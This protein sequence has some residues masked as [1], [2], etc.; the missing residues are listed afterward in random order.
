MPSTALHTSVISDKGCIEVTGASIPTLSAGLL[1]HYTIAGTADIVIKRLQ[2]IQ[3]TVACSF[4]MRNNLPGPV[5]L[6]YVSRVAQNRFQEHNP[7]SM[8]SVYNWLKFFE[9]ILGSEHQTD[10]QYQK[11]R[12]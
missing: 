1:Q 2:S 11:Y 4:S 12:Y 7:V 5:S 6:F 10:I 3:N 9:V 8:N